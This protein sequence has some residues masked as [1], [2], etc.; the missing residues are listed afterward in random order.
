MSFDQCLNLLQFA[1]HS[2]VRFHDNIFLFLIRAKL[3]PT[4]SLIIV[5][6]SAVSANP[7]CFGIVSF[8]V[9]CIILY[10][11]HIVNAR[12]DSIGSNTILEIMMPASIRLKK[13]QFRVCE[14]RP[15]LVWCSQASFT[16]RWGAVSA[17]CASSA[18]ESM[19]PQE[20]L[21]KMGFPTS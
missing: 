14:G 10:G 18:Q 13:A 20:P 16:L 5:S 19:H 9:T 7:A 6:M 21:E 17:I 2:N 4:S 11:G 3:Q 8:D 12:F 15:A 1:S